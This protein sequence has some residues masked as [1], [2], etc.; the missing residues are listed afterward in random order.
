MS[1]KI[2]IIEQEV[3]GLQ[4]LIRYLIRISHLRSF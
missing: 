2:T 1:S 3:L 4:L